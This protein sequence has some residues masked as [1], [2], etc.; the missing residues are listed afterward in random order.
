MQTSKQDLEKII[1]D[2]LD[3]TGYELITL[4]ISP[5]N[6]I[7]VEVDSLIVRIIEIFS[8]KQSYIFNMMKQKAHRGNR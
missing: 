6:E 5:E 4:E 3:G 2:N 7:L 1:H 8:W